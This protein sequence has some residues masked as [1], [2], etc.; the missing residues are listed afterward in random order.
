MPL[1]KRASK[2]AFQQNIKKEVASGKP[3]R[4][5]LAIAFSVKRKTQRGR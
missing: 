4:Q 2:L 5:A 3:I 1:I